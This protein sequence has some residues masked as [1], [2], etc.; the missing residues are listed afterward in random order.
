M[1]IKTFIHISLFF[2][3]ILRS[4]ILKSGNVSVG[5]SILFEMF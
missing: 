1:E 4:L 2:S 5:I 3:F